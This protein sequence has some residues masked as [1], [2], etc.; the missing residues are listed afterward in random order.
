MTKSQCD[1]QNVHSPSLLCGLLARHSSVKERGAIPTSVR[2]QTGHAQH[3]LPGLHL[4]QPAA[5]QRQGSQLQRAVVGNRCFSHMPYTGA[6][7][8]LDRC[9]CFS[10]FTLECHIHVCLIFCSF[11]LIQTRTS[12]QSH[13]HHL[14]PADS[15]HMIRVLKLDPELMANGSLQ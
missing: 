6:V 2:T 4:A 9:L 8:Q 15:S 12:H 3:R 11:R 1:V 10:T 5:G 7:E 13:V 14:P